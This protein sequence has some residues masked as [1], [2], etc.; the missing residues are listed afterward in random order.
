MARPRTELHEILKDLDGVSD[1]YFQAPS[2]GMLYPCIIYEPSTPNDVSF[3]DNVKYLRKKG[4]TVIVV[5]RDPD[6]LIPDQ[7]EELPY[8]QFDRYYRTN[9][10]HHFAFK[11]FF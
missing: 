5:D 9:G 7:V 3:A 8:S 6:S 1:A 4:Y 10:L 11:L 2:S